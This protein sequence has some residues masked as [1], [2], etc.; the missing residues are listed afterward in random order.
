MV[1]AKTQ[2]PV[3][4]LALVVACLAVPLLSRAA[5][6]IQFA[7]AI[8]GVVTNALG[9]PQMGASVVLYNRQ[10]RV[11]E[12]ALTDERGEF[13]FAGLLPELYSIRVSLATFVPALKRD[14][15]VQPG[16]RSVLNVSLNT[17][18]SSIQIAYPPPENSS[19]M[20]DDWKWMLRTAASTRPVLRFTGD[21]LGKDP[22][23][24][25]HASLFS[26]TRGV[27]KLSAGDGPMVTGIGN[28]ADMGTA[29]ALATSVLGNNQLE[30]SGNL[31]YGSQTGVPVAAFRTSYSR[32][33]SGGPEVSVTMRQLFL[34]GRLGTAATGSES[35][36]PML[37]S[38]SASLDDRTE[39]TDELSLQYGFTLDSVSFGD[40]LS[41]FSPYA[42]LSY[43]L[44][45][46]GTL[47]VAYT[48]G[49]ARPDLAGGVA[50]DSD[51]QRDLNTIGLFPRISL[52]GG[53]PKIQRG[54]ELE[55][56]YTRRVGSR[57]YELSAYRESVVN[58][59][60]SL[61]SAADLEPSSDL[62]PD[63][64]TGN[65][66]FNAGNYQGVG[67]TAAV[68]QNL[69]ERFSA[70]LMY[71]T[72]NGLTA[73]QGEIVSGS[74]DELRSL[75]RSG[76][77]QAATA[78]ITATSPWT[79]TH[80]IASYQWSG[81]HRWV[82]PG[83]LYTTQ[84][85]RAMPGLNV[86]FRQPIPGLSILPWRVEATADLRNLLAEG[87]LPLGSPNG[88]QAVLVQNPRSFRG[89]F[90]FIF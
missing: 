4:A 67:Y 15:L 32:G 63:L 58:A 64:F 89:G 49:N 3:A 70:T 86:Y 28:E 38:V 5:A 72:M 21:A 50:Q 35:A 26:D 46:N 33:G 9:T 56:T 27:L 16:M 19:F 45:D 20:T 87:Y 6:P 59:A 7:G 41:Y 82:M 10:E 76:R 1:N 29:F 55:L 52:L 85:V 68:T 36:L 23:Q 71:G 54:T 69:G 30:V 34:P 73:G 57:T 44:G 13:K 11:Y 80:M 83:R 2:K 24:S 79:G 75:I 48:S 31:G 51:L 78:R 65:A 66:I 17:L 25:S 8:G 39:L 77:R 40:H 88:L 61:V 47:A 90:S 53:R 62:L 74:P 42:R 12:K 60:L 81:D 84:S 14:I 43:S 22:G 37:R 18:F